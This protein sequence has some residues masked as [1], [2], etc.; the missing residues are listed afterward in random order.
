MGRAKLETGEGAVTHALTP[1]QA[2]LRERPKARCRCYP[3]R[4]ILER[5]TVMDSYAPLGSGATPQLAWIRSKA[6]L[7]VLESMT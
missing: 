4:S 7:K 2:V 6:W 1:R 5:Y 3:S